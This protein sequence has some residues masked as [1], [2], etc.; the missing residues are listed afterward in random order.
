MFLTVNM[1][2]NLV[3]EIFLGK[4]SIMSFAG[5]IRSHDTQPARNVHK[6]RRMM[7]LFLSH[8]PV[9]VL[10]FPLSLVGLLIYSLSPPGIPIM[11]RLNFLTF[12][13]I[14]F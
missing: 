2:H 1:F 5:V 6:I 10:G 8:G 3:H 7:A 9:F 13:F 12:L 4:G 14:Y 11:V